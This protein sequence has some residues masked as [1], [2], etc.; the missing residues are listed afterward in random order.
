MELAVSLASKPKMVLLDE[1]S[2]GLPSAEAASFA[3]IVRK[4]T[5]N[6]TLLF[7]A[8]DM[9]LVF[10]LADKIMV[11]YSGRILT[12]GLPEDI[13]ANKQVQEIYL[14][15]EEDESKC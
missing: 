14:G 3:N 5:E 8:H 2:A 12:K 9:D 7:C 1:P 13:K 11:L 10:N 6:T 4:L 15:T